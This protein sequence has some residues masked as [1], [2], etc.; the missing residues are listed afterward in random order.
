MVAKCHG[1]GLNFFSLNSPK[2]R[3]IRKDAVQR[4]LQEDPAWLLR[5]DNSL[6]DLPEQQRNR[7]RSFAC[8]L[9]ASRLAT[10]WQSAKSH[11][12][13]KFLKKEKEE[14][15]KRG[16]GEDGVKTCGECQSKLIEI[17]P[18]CD[19]EQPRKKRLVFLP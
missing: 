14:S 16:R 5:W 2:Q 8:D 10:I 11:G 9:L 4:Y 7:A 1:E 18:C 17:C 19:T 6:A 15:G 3:T 13:A 12:K